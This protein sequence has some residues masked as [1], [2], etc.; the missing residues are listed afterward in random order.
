M[1][2][3]LEHNSVQSLMK[4]HTKG[5]NMSGNLLQ[6]QV[7]MCGGLFMK[8]C[9]SLNLL[10]NCVEYWSPP[11]ILLFFI[12]NYC[13][14]RIIIRISNIQHQILSPLQ[15]SPGWVPKTLST[16]SQSIHTVF[17]RSIWCCCW[18]KC[19][20]FLLQPPIQFSQY[21]S[22]NKEHISLHSRITIIV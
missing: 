19:S 16:F 9:M 4:F 20:I 12:N 17:L 15:M 3:V 14:D 21:T 18:F 13:F 22:F 7:Q 11:D 10:C 1:Q 5:H 2:L 8:F 6:H